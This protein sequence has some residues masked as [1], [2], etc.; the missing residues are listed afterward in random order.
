MSTEVK[1]D[2]MGKVTTSRELKDK[3]SVMRRTRRKRKRV[4]KRG[5]QVRSAFLHRLGSGSPR[6]S[7]QG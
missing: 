4:Q 5:E 2:C 3:K 7:A 1:E 6:Q